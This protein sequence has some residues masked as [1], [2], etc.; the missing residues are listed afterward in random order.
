[1]PTNP[2]GVYISAYLAIPKTETTCD[3]M[4]INIFDLQLSTAKHQVEHRPVN[5]GSSEH[6]PR[7]VWGDRAC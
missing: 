1:M 4:G 3:R 5:Y 7:V 6:L 2:V